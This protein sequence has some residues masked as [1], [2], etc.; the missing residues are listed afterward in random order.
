MRLLDSGSG[1]FHIALTLDDP[2]GN[3]R[4]LTRNVRL[5]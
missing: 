4:T 2:V 1:G 3:E 5:P